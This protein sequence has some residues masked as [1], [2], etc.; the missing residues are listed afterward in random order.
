MDRKP[1]TK[2]MPIFLKLDLSIRQ[3]AAIN[4]SNNSNNSRK[5]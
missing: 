4:N 1:G 2:D 5:D 3:A